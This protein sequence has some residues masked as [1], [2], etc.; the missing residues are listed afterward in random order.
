M[1]MIRGIKIASGTGM[2]SWSLWRVIPG[3]ER[4]VLKMGKHM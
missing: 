2:S 1:R 4:I 3:L